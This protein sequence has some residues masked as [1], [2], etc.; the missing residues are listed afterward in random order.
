MPGAIV[1]SLLPSLLAL[2]EEDESRY[3]DRLNMMY[4]LVTVLGVGA[5]L[6]ITFSA[7]PI[8][9]NSIRRRVFKRCCRDAG[10]GM[11]RAFRCFGDGTNSTHDSGKLPAFALVHDHRRV[12]GQYCFNHTAYPDLRYIGGCCGDG[13]WVCGGCVAHE[14]RLCFLAP[15]AVDDVSFI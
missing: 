15:D 8:I 3:R 7:E 6:I 14:P 2:K 5:A 13:M 9:D 12:V 1:T 11:G 10:N 4:E